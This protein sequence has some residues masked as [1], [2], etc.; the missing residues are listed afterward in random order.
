MAAIERE[1]PVIIDCAGSHLL[2]ILHRG[3]TDPERAVLIVVGGPQY[4]VGSHRQ[5][6]LLARQLAAAGYPVLR[7]DG[8]GMGDSDGQPRTFETIQDDIAATIDCL[9][10]QYPSLRHLVL[11]G[12]CDAASAIARYA[13]GDRRVTGLVLLNPWVRTAVGEARTYL[14]HSYIPRLLSRQFWRKLLGGGVRIRHSLGALRAFLAA[15]GGPTQAP[16][17]DPSPLP[18]LMLQGLCAF[19]GQVLLILSGHDLTA[20]E[21]AGLLKTDRAWARW[22]AQNTV[23][24]HDLNDA[25]HTFSREPWRRE[26]E[27]RT[28]AWLRSQDPDP[29]QR[30]PDE[31][32]HP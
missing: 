2:G 4:R 22:V 5:F 14:R 26:V 3:A 31:T 18:N 23:M 8:R 19:R 16:P 1:L 7:F 24:R 25:D 20:S 15:A 30:V 21:F 12:L 13:A 32:A 9:F 29:L 11:W 10:R 17:S 6:V 27:T 28:L